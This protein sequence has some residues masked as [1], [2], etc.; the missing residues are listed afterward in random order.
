MIF[1]LAS[2]TLPLTYK[3]C[4]LLL[5]I[6]SYPDHIRP[7]IVMLPTDHCPTTIQS[8]KLVLYCKIFLDA[9]QLHNENAGTN[10]LDGCKCRSANFGID[11]AAGE[12]KSPGYPASY[13]NNLNCKYEIDA[14]PGQSIHLSVVSFETE[15]RHDF[16]EIHQTFIFANTQ[17]SARI[18]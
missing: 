13:C 18:A 1:F 5:V 10:R 15:L 9:F 4:L 7:S 16:L 6:R 11:V 8:T 2:S 17:Y 12:L 3:H 14:V